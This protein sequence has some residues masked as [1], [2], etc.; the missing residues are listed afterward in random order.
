[1]A[2]SDTQNR[3]FVLANR[4]KGEPDETTLRLETGE[5]PVPG[6]GQMLLRNEFLSLDP[7]MR[8]RM[9]DAPSYAAPVE[10]GQ[11][12]VGG[13]VSTVVSSDVDGFSEGDRVVAFGGWQDYALSDGTGLI[14]MGKSPE[15]PSWALGVLG[16]PG[17][18]A[19][20]GLTQIG[21]P[22]EGETLVVAGASGRWAPRSGRSASC[23][24]CARSASPAGPRN[25]PM[26]STPWGSMP[27]STTRPKASPTR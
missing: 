12:M 9:S 13:T 10:I 4:P 16:M 3:K 22:K 17:L 15:N 14:N 20:A 26:W 19:W 25:A 11:V 18:T 8:G 21:Q 1:M 5:V 23:L 7:Y 24:V 2:Q 27:A 6:P